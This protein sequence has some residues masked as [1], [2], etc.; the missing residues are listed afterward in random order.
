MKAAVHDEYGGPEVLR[1]AD[2]PVPEPGAGEVLVRVRA[3][4]VNEWDLGLLTGTPLVNRSAGLRRPRQR[5]I[6]S[7]L[8]GTVA[9]IGPGVVRFLPG[10]EVL[11]DL[12]ASGF[13]AFADYACAP[14]SALHHK[15]ECLGWAEAASVPQAGTLAIEGLRKGRPYRPGQRVLING[16]GGGA[17]TLAVQIAKHLQAEVTAVDAGGKLP[18]LVGLGA[19]HVIDY[20]L[21]DF[22]TTGEAYDLIVDMASSR[23]V[24][25]YRRALRPRGACGIVGGGTPQLLGALALGSLLLL[26]RGKRLSL[27]AHRANDHRDMALLLDLLQRGSIQ[28]VV[29]R[30]FPLSEAR[31]A[32]RYYTE[33][34]FVG[35]IVLTMCTGTLPEQAGN[36]TSG[37]AGCGERE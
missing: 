23:S 7:D 12:S 25:D 6:G 35:K 11:A 10:D 21:E 30:T 2:I 26:D 14:E 28:P 16:A 1:I 34:T 19:D 8:A 15:P 24:L 9:A 32:M 13:G 18:A 17:G 36:G 5:T 33:G 3:A 20:A 31:Q 37:V 4:S 27:V 22:A 29:D